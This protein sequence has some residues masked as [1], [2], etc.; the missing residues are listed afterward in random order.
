M[1][2]LISEE[3]LKLLEANKIEQQKKTEEII[4]AQYPCLTHPPLS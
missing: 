2:P 3:T 1:K 4:K